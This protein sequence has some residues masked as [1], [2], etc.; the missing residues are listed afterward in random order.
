MPNPRVASCIFCD[1][2]RLEVGN[3][4]SLMG[5]LGGDLSV[6]ADFPV[7][8]PKFGIMVLV[9]SDIADP[10]QHLV[11]TIILPDG[12]EAFK[13]E[14]QAPSVIENAEGATQIKAVQTIPISPL[15]LPCEGMLEV[16]VETERE[17]IRA[18]RLRIHR[19]NRA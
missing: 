17:K 18:G 16:W 14:A 6:D 7:L 11:T 2:I 12:V 4:L 3:K 13:F 9:I 15:P 8:L 10:I 1:D 5:V 19:L